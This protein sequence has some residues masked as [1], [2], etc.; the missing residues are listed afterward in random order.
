MRF[1]QLRA[2]V[3]TQLPGTYFFAVVAMGPLA[4]VA[5][6]A[7]REVHLAARTPIWIIP[8]VL[9][10]GQ[11]LTTTTGIWWTRSPSRPRLHA[12]VVA[13]V[14]VVTAAIYATGWGPALAIGLV[15]IGQET[16]TSAGS[17]AQHMVFGWCLAGLVIGQGLIALGWVP[18]LI[19]SPEVHGL[20]V[21]VVVGIA[22]SHRA[23]CSALTDKEQATRETEHQEHKFRALL[24]SSH[25]LVFVFDRSAAVTYAS[26]SCQQ[27]LGFP[28]EQLLGPN[29]EAKIHPDDLDET[30][31]AMQ[32]VTDSD[33]RRVELLFRIRRGDDSWCWVEGV[34]TNLFADPIVA[35]VV[36]NV[37]D[38]ADRIAAEDAIR[39]QALH[40]PL[41]GLANRTL[42]ADRLQ[43]AIDRRKRYGGHVGALIV[44]L[45]G[46]KTVNDSLGHTVG[47]ELLV[48]VARRFAGVVRSHETVARLG[49]DEFAVLIEDLHRVPDEA[50]HVAARLLNSLQSPIILAERE[51]AIGASIGIAIAEQTDDAAHRL[52]A[53]ADAAMYRAKREG[54][55]CYRVFEHSMVA[56]AK[57]RLELEQDLRAAV[58]ERAIT[59]HYQPIVNIHTNRATGFEALARWQHPLRG[60]IPPD[61]FIPIAEE[62]NLILEIGRQILAQACEQITRWRREYPDLDLDLAINVSQLQLAHPSLA[63]DIGRTLERAG[64]PP[65]ALV[66]EITESALANDSGR[67]INT[68]DR[69]RRT[70]IRVAIDD[71]G[72]GYSSFAA[73]A[74]L[75]I[76][77]LKIDK[78]FIDNLTQHHQ[79]RGFVNAIIELARTLELETVA[80]GVEHPEQCQALRELGGTHLQGYI[81]SPP[82]TPT[83]ADEYLANHARSAE[84]T[85]R[86]TNA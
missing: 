72:T 34:A 65:T 30:R 82:L 68:L 75:P 33:G 43:Q 57:Q 73:L 9:V 2:Y 36:V 10:G 17:S 7:L 19:P 76:D 77:I 23:L 46:F 53:H 29:Q 14:A 11:M 50:M 71:F 13:H 35:G 8:T 44:D 60:R 45:D 21:L 80:E 58:S 41:T 39:H 56:A 27:V 70:G 47:D 18:S 66:L 83:D 3:A 42:L 49:G 25:D 55:G 6:L 26:P 32:T 78:R 69:L 37:R 20:A 63:N 22:F 31:R 74:E 24:Q 62:T 15:L 64:L 38:V 84:E 86:A 67:A 59:A 1:R 81:H 5:I 54:K 85:A 61:V 4:A 79:G 40:D 48:G 52:L 12:K 16:L 51:V 28:P